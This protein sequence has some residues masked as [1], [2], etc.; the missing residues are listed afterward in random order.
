[1][2]DRYRNS[3]DG[4]KLTTNAEGLIRFT[5]EE[6]GAYWLNT[7]AEGKSMLNGKDIGVRSSYVVTFEALPH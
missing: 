6:A 4:L 3:E 7:G 5:L 2:S 1:G